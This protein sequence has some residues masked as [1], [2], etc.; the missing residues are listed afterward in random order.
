MQKVFDC[1]QFFGSLPKR[2][3]ETAGKI[4]FCKKETLLL[5]RWS[6]DFLKSIKQQ[7]IVYWKF[8]RFFSNF[9]RLSLAETFLGQMLKFV[10]L[11]PFQFE[12]WQFR[13]SKA[14]LKPSFSGHVINHCLLKSTG[15][16][17]RSFQS[18]YLYRR[19]PLSFLSQKLKNW[20]AACILTV[21]TSNG[22]HRF[23][24]GNRGSA[25]FRKLYSLY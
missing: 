23:V 4:Y 2:I 7:D 24:V 12:S 13:A 18:I 17:Q 6:G 15:K 14:F 25:S 1:R 8:C 9:V 20:R 11:Q 21:L 22:R 10:F 16:N 19:T 3:L 5:I